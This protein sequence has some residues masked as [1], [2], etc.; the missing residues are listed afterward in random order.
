MSAQH[1]FRLRNPALLLA[2][3][4]AFPAV[5]SADGTANVDFSIG[6]VMAVNAAG[7]ARPLS[8]GGGIGNGDTVRTGEGGRAQIRFTDGAL[9][10]LQPQTEF[11]ID[12]YQYS[13]NPDGQEKGFFSLLKGGLR[14]VTG[15][16]GRSKRENYKV[17]TSVATIGIRGTE[18]TAGLSPSGDSLAVATGEGLVEVCN[19]AGCI[20]LASGESGVAQKD[21]PPRRDNSR[22]QLPPNDTLT[23]TTGDQT[24]FIGGDQVNSAGLP[25]A[26]QAFTVGHVVNSGGVFHDNSTISFDSAGNLTGYTSGTFTSSIGTASVADSGTSD[27]IIKWGRWAS[28]TAVVDNLSVT[29]GASQGVHLLWGVPTAVMPTSGTVAYSLLGGTSP[30]EAGGLLTPGTLSSA[31]MSVN[32]GALTF[33]LSLS[34]SVGGPTAFSASGSGSLTGNKLS[35]SSLTGL[36]GACSATGSVSG[37]FFGASAERSGLTYKMSDGTYTI[38]GAA[39][40]KQ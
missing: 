20:L 11:R 27:S 9:V 21:S 19:G 10:S 7:I 29:L 16:I 40:L 28:G 30:T 3:A 39:A 26:G 32:F 14:T 38:V 25:A 33:S 34:G 4:A 13:G 5:S 35:S 37:M 36:I 15:W 18:Y 31:S 8:K 2:L 1:I 17:T 24:V 6:S 12:D 23:T 22:P